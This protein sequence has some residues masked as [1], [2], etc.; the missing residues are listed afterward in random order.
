MQALGAVSQQFTQRLAQLV[1]LQL[2]SPCQAQAQHWHCQ[3]VVALPNY[4][5]LQRN[6]STFN[7]VLQVPKAAKS[8]QDVLH[9]F[10]GHVSGHCSWSLIVTL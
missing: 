6:M 4:I 3:H 2:G 5:H 9:C 7:Q 1:A 10:G 8:W